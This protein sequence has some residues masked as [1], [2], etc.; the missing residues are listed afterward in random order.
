M[1]RLGALVA[2]LL[3]SFVPAFA[4]AAKS[5]SPSPDTVIVLDRGACEQ[6]CAVYRIVIFAD[7]SVIY[8][9]RYFVGHPGLVHSGIAPEVLAGLVADL[10]AGGFFQLES[11]Y[12]YGNRDHC[13]AFEAGEPAAILTVSANGRAK[14]VLH[15][16]GCAGAASKHLT[17]LEDKVDRAVGA[18]KWIKGPEKAR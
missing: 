10:N 6:R 9:G 14:T 11:N 15:N 18:A 2:A 8:D 5:S 4:Q 7:G 12:G 1:I 3:V 16:H 17:E 13:D